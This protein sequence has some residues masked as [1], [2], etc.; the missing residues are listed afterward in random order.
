MNSDIT[1]VG[2]G[3]SGGPFPGDDPG[4]PDGPVLHGAH[5][6]AD[7][8]DPEAHLPALPAAP[9]R[10]RVLRPSAPARAT[11]HSRATSGLVR[12]P[13]PAAF[14]RPARAGG[15]RPAVA[16]GRGRR[17]L[18][19]PRPAYTGR[20]G[21]DRV[22]S[23]RAGQ[24]RCAARADWP[25][26]AAGGALALLGGLGRRLGTAPQRGVAGAARNG[27]TVLLNW[28]KA[29]C[30][31]AAV[32]GVLPLTPRAIPT[33][34]TLMDALLPRGCTTDLWHWC[35]GSRHRARCGSAGRGAFAR[36]EPAVHPCGRDAR[37]PSA[38]FAYQRSVVHPCRDA[39][40]MPSGNI[41]C[42]FFS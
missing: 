14:G 2:K 3:I 42:G 27:K 6:H 26:G 36:Q 10:T 32:V 23:V 8:I 25:R 11:C 22:T 38:A 16:R 7:A 5:R 17:P 31:D 13:H 37:A 12:T 21:A 4:C 28:L 41:P 30:F 34:Q 29:A 9:V 40:R 35:L 39:C 19:T 24:W 33:P 20:H 18:A 15:T 1:R